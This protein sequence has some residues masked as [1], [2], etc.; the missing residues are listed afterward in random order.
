MT[1]REFTIG[2]CVVIVKRPELSE[3]ERAKREKRVQMALQQAGRAMQKK[4]A[5]EKRYA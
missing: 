5:E 4:P 3:A 2:N 1:T